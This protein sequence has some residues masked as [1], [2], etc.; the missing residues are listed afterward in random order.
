MIRPIDTFLG[1]YLGSALGVILITPV[2]IRLAH[3]LGAVDRP[4]VRT[5]HER[6][7]PRLG[8]VAVFLSTMGLIAA[9]VLWDSRL[10]EEFHADRLRLLVLLTAAA[11]I[12]LIGLVDDLRGLPARVKFLAELLA[13][14]ALCAAGVE[15]RSI[16]PTD[17]F[18]LALGGWGCLFT[19]FWIV[20]ITNAVNLCDGLD[21]LAAGVSAITCAVLAA[22]AVHGGDGMVGV[23][24][25]ALLGSLSG[26]LVFNFY[27]AKIF[28]GDGGSLFLGFLIAATSVLC[29]VRSGTWAGLALPAMT[30]GIP[31]FDTL[32]SML[33]RFLDRRSMFAPDRSH[34]HHRLLDL[35]LHHRHAVLM[36]YAATLLAA[37]MGL[38]VL[39]SRPR[40]SLI[41]CGGTLL[42]IVLLFRAVGAIR[43]RE[44]LVRL[45][46]RYAHARQEREDQRIFEHLQLRFRQVRDAGQW[47]QAICE[48]AGHMDFAWISVKTM[49]PDGRTEEE[50]WQSSLEERDVSQLV[51]MMLPIGG[52]DVSVSRRF[53]I[54]IHLNGSLETANRRATLFGRLLD[55][56]Q[57]VTDRRYGEADHGVAMVKADEYGE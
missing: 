28:L 50:W 25:L 47:W 40:E 53:E 13:A 1:T 52:N 29:V 19:L 4:G 55:E 45:R 48:A 31:I 23:L 10:R 21:G 37:G 34:F 3:H 43:L 2:V 27:P 38:I 8:G 49:Y 36:I 6:P 54:A 39:R 18:V 20:G 5:V 33:R 56:R 46:H 16:G 17:G 26:F 22:C 44:T 14:G 11:A 9:V 51:T 32:F 15:I 57:T 41:L 7:V 12:F 30:L 42:L 24:M 35:G